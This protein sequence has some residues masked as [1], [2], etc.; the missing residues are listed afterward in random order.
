MLDNY[1]PFEDSEIIIIQSLL[2]NVLGGGSG[3]IQGCLRL[4]NLRA[5][6]RRKKGYIRF[7][8]MAENK[9]YPF[10]YNKRKIRKKVDTDIV[11]PKAVN[12][13]KDRLGKL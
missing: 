10:G 12:F 13:A 2:G 5:Q 1:L 7:L 4:E 8:E 3:M 11:E 9:S 6:R